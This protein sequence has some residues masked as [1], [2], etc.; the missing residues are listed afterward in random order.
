MDEYVPLG[1]FIPLSEVL[2]LCVRIDH[3]RDLERIHHVVLHYLVLHSLQL[4]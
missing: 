3:D 4:L 2:D 1:R